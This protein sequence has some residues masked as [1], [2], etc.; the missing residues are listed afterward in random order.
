MR[1]RKAFRIAMMIT[2]IV[3]STAVCAWSGPPRRGAESIAG[4]PASGI[5]RCVEHVRV[6]T[7][8][9]FKPALEALIPQIERAT[10]RKVSPE[11]D[12]SKTLQQKIE[13]GGIGSTQPF[14]RPT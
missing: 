9:G 6:Y 11:F 5:T 12:A 7:S 1:L 10:G 2:A 3:A 4:G 14:C 8:D 13:S